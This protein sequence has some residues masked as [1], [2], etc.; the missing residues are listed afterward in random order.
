MQV[1]F[2]GRGARWS[3][4][5]EIAERTETDKHQPWSLKVAS[6]ADTAEGTMLVT[7]LAASAADEQAKSTGEEADV[8]L[9]RAFS[10]AMVAELGLRPLG[11]GFRFVVDHRWVVGY[12]DS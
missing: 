1:S 4:A 2:E 8:I 11:S 10:R 9:G 12:Q 7:D 3:G 5:A 6:G